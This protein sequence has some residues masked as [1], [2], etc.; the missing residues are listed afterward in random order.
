MHQMS[1]NSEGELQDEFKAP[2][3]ECISLVIYLTDPSR[4]IKTC[5]LCKL[6]HEAVPDGITL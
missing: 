4:T 3:I 6:I 1:Y 5:S 2:D